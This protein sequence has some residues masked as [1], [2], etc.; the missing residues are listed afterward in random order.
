M[1][2]QGPTCNFIQI[3]VFN[4]STIMSLSQV[5][6]ET[7]PILSLYV[8]HKINEQNHNK[9]LGA[10]EGVPN[11]D[12]TWEGEKILQHPNLKFLEDK[13]YLVE[14]TIMSPFL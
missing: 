1:G 11:E 12:A 2:L 3:V 13:K 4:L 14:R 7:C 10:Q 5:L 6:L 9:A 8:S